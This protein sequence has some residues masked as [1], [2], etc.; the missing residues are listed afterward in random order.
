MEN[1]APRISALVPVKDRRERM[2]RCMDALLAQDHPDYEIVV[3]DNGSTD[4]TPEACTERA[5]GSGVPVRIEVIAGSVGHVRN[6][7]ARLARANVVAFTDSDCLPQREWLSA[8]EK[9]FAD[10]GVGIVTGRT[11]PEEEPTADWP[12]TIEV[13]GPTKRFESC[14]VFFRREAFIATPGFDEEI[15]HFWEDTAAGF[16]MLRAGWEVAYAD[17][18]LVLHDVTYPGWVWQLQRAQKHAHLAAVLRKY[19][20]LRTELLWGRVFLRPRDAMIAAFILGL[21]L[22]PFDRRAL[23]LTAPYA[24]HRRPGELH[25]KHLLAVAKGT[26]FELAVFVGVVRGGLRYRQFVL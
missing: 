13:I 4:G 18:A 8:G 14:N 26:I 15:G 9:P 1:G 10:S 20:E 22:A 12:A 16:A 23:A 24:Y 19:P 5:R 3:L 2:L 11:L 25:P 6:Q 21:A 17:N 7:G